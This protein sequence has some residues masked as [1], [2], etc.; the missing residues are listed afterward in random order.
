MLGPLAFIAVRQQQ[1]EPAHAQPFRLARTQKLVDDNLGAIGE[2]AELRLPQHQSGGIGEA[3]A[4]FEAD[5]PSFGEWAVDNLE[6]RL[7]GADVIDRYVALFGL[8]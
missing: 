2:I 8:L 7:P 4:I 6:R 3:V 5:H 1:D